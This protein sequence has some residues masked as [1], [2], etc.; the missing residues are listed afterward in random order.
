MV[1]PAMP[2]LDIIRAVRERF[3]LP[4]AAYNVSGEYA[5][6]K[7]AAASG[8]MDERQ[9]ALESLT[10]IRRAGA[11]VIVTYWAK[12]VAPLAIGTRSKAL[13]AR[14]ARSPAGSTRRC[15]RCGRWASTSRSSS[16]A[17][18][19]PISRTSTAAAT[20]TG[21]SR[22][23]HSSSATP[24]RRRSRPFAWLRRTAPASAPRPSG[25]SSSPPRSSMPCP[26]SRWSARLVRDRGSD[27]GDPPRPGRDPPRPDPQ[28]RR[29]YHGHADALLA[30]AGSGVATLGIP[31]SAG[32]PAKVT[33]DTIVSPY[34]DLEAAAAAVAQYGEGLACVIVEP[35]AGNMGVVPPAAGFLDG[36]RAVR[37]ERRVADLRRGDHRFPTGPRRSAGA[38][39][40]PPGPDDSREDR[41]RR[42]PLAAFG[43][44]ADVMQELAP[45]GQVYQA[46]TLSGNPLATAAG[47]AVLRRLRD[48][49]VYEARAPR[50]PP[51]SRRRAVRPLRASGR[52]GHALRRGHR[53]LRGAFRHLLEQGVYVAPSQFEA[54]FISLAHGDEEIERTVDAVAGFGG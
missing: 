24:I 25:R 54:M 42:T 18:T 37:R 52:D 10:A 46:G 16:V 17:A 38:L 27:V 19:A 51:R 43:G 36:L 15:G 9:A 2:N 14:P 4:V 13:G 45:T 53:G 20:W 11:D 1:K 6:V 30:E 7:A 48:D 5:M 40:R 21:C 49:G 44:R 3:D 28:V 22:G 29:L 47:L 32:V 50:S 26:P 12:D 33:A 35:V 23:A 34:N 8:W 41:R 39:R 31:S